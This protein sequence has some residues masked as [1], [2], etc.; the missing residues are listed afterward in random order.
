MMDAILWQPRFGH[1]AMGDLNSLGIF[2]SPLIFLDQKYVHATIYLSDWDKLS[3]LPASKVHPE[4][5]DDYVTDFT[6]TASR[7][8]QGDIECKLHLR[9]SSYPRTLTEIWIPKDLAES[10][11]TSPPEGFKDA[12]FKDYENFFSER[13]V[14]WGGNL[15]LPTNKDL[16][17]TIPAKQPEAGSGKIRFECQLEYHSKPYDRLVCF[18]KLP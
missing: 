5:R 17:L 13:Y 3:Y 2:Y 15:L 1:A 16:L 18:A 11:K 8:D 9:G 14:R 6:A 12:P 7:N 10:L 4:L